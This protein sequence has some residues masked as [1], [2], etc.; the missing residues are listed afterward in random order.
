MTVN[1]PEP[2][3]VY[4]T[5]ETE[6]QAQKLGRALVELKLAACVNIL[7]GCRSIYQWQGKLENTH[8][9][10]MFIKTNG[11]CLDELLVQAKQ[12]HPYDTPALL[13]LPIAG[14]DEDYLSW[15]AGQVKAG[16]G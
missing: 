11:D 7:P 4:S 14:G 15:A 10:V 9:C 3:F 6:A 12:L 13:V 2:V 1:I 16:G 5:V 8:E